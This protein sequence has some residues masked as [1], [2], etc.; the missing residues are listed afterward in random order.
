MF[1]NSFKLNLA[2]IAFYIMIPV[3]WPTNLASGEKKNNWLGCYFHWLTEIEFGVC[4][5][6]IKNP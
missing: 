4:S 3:F 1:G 5:S 6:S 2:S